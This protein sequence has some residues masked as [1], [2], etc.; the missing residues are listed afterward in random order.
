MEETPPVKAEKE[1]LQRGDVARAMIL[2]ILPLEDRSSCRMFPQRLLVVL[3]T[4]VL[5]DGG[6][7]GVGHVS[8][9]PM[10]GSPLVAAPMGGRWCRGL[11]RQGVIHV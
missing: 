11:E 5:E 6:V 1:L 10:S 9:G 8:G 2:A 4:L 7:A 3:Y